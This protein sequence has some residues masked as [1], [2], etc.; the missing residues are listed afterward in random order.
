MK[1]KFT[2]TIVM[3][4]SSH[5]ETVKFKP[6]FKIY[7]FVDTRLNRFGFVDLLLGDL[8]PLGNRVLHPYE[9]KQCTKKCCLLQKEKLQAQKISFHLHGSMEQNHALKNTSNNTHLCDKPA[10]NHSGLHQ[11]WECPD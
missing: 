8:P 9:E 11:I 2:S 1:R 6:L 4:S 10:R 5:F 3:L 7:C